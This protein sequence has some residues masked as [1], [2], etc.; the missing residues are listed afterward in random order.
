MPC[1]AEERTGQHRQGGLQVRHEDPVDVVR[2]GEE[3]VL[4]VLLP[5]L[6]FLLV[7]QGEKAVGLS[8][9]LG[10][11]PEFALR[12]GVGLRRRF[13]VGRSQLIQQAG[14]DGQGEKR[15]CRRVT[16]GRT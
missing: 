13:P 4:L 6:V 7:A 11:V 9:A 16:P 3:L 8:P 5:C 14:G 1:L 15:L 12:V 10:L 2:G